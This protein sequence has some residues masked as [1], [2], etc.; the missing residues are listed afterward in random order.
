MDTQ[1]PAHHTV[2]VPNPPAHRPRASSHASGSYYE[3]VDPRFAE[4][5]DTVPALSQQHDPNQHQTQAMH[6]GTYDSQNLMTGS[7]NVQLP[8]AS[9]YD[10]LPVGARSPAESDGS[11][12]TSVSQRGVNPN[13]RPGHG[14]EFNNLGPRRPQQAKQEVLLANNPD[15]ELMPPPARFNG[16]GG[17][18]GFRGGPTGGGGGGRMLPPSALAMS[19]DSP[20]PGPST[21]REI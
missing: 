14:G 11:H 7:E 10:E 3:D 13:W 9:S 18:A 1:A 16:R 17:R 12:F 2:T 8:R 4:S 19:G 6:S 20:Y 15:F 5:A 21:M